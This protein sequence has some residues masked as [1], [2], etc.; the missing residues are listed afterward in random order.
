[1]EIR[2]AKP[3]Q[4]ETV[5]QLAVQL[6]PSHTKEELEEE[7]RGLLAQEDAAVFL[8]YVQTKAVGFAQC[9]L[10]RDYVEGASSSP[11][12]YLEGIFVLPSQRGQGVGRQL[13]ARCEQWSLEKGCREMGSDCA[14]EN[15][16]SW[17]FHL[18]SGFLEAGRIICFVKDLD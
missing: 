5:A 11:V 17:Q 18:R 10:R 14:L 4:W 9:S 2:Q 16:E 8:A 7:F 1:M 6:W 15:V 13:L 12:G 3:C